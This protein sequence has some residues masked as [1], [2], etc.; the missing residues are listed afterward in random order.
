MCGIDLEVIGRSERAVHFSIR[1]PYLFSLYLS[2]RNFFKLPDVD[3]EIS[4]RIIE[5]SIFWTLWRTP[6]EWHSGDWR[7]DSFNLPNFLR[8]RPKHS[9]RDISTHEVDI[10]MP[11]GMYPAK[12]RLYESTWRYPRWFP[13]RLVR[14]E[15]EMVK[16]IPV[17]GKGENSWDIDDDAIFGGTYHASTIPEAIAA[18]TRSAYRDREKYGGSVAWKQGE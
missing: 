16:P 10:P 4:V 11:E 9:E 1:I 13:R 12:I 14:A 17:P 2:F 3:R 5:G 6:H 15:I 7:N 8:G 18:I